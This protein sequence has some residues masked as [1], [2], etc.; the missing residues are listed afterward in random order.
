MTNHPNINWRKRWRVD[1]ASLTAEHDSGLRVV[2]RLNPDG[3]LDVETQDGT[4]PALAPGATS[5][6][7]QAL[8]RALGRR[9][10]EGGRLLLEALRK[11]RLP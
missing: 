10:E 2:G 11:P 9:V 6:D 7:V 5:A 8:G 3:S 1:P 4:L